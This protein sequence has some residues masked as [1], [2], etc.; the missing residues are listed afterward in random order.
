MPTEEADAVSGENGK[1]TEGETEYGEVLAEEDVEC[2]NHYPQEL[3]LAGREGTADGQ[4]GYR[5]Q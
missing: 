5:A 2:C 1:Q 3:L 4:A